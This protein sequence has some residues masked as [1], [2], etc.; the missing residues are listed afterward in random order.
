LLPFV[1]SENTDMSNRKKRLKMQ[2]AA[3]AAFAL[4]LLAAVLLAGVIAP[5]DPYRTNATLIRTPPCADYP[6]G[7]DNMGRCVF[8]RVLYGGRTTITATFFLVAVSFGIGTFIGILCGFYGGLFDRILMRIADI[9]LSFPQMVVAIAVAGILGGGLTGAMVALG[10]TMWV[11]FARLARSHT[12]AIRNEPYIMTAQL[13]GKSG[14]YIMT[15]HILPNILAPI[16]TNALTQIGTTMIG[17]SGLSFLGLGVVPPTAE[18]GSMISEGRAYIQI[19]PWT[20]LFPA[21]ATVL[22][23]TVFNYLGDVVMDYRNL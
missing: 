4:L 3:A 14:L 2:I 12:I 1:G 10:I 16:L 13:A 23:I 18:W 20:V 5:N 19:A 17:I 11:A 6:F 7:T 15:R 9:F 8:S 21:L 22:T